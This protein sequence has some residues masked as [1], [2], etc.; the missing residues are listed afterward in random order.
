MESRRNEKNGEKTSSPKFYFLNLPEARFF[1]ALCSI[2]V[3]E[4]SDPLNEPGALTVGAINYIDST[5]FNFPSE[6]QAYFREAIDTINKHSQSQFSKEFSDLS[7][8]DKNIVLRGLYLDPKTRELSFDLRSLAL[9][10]FYSDYHDP[11]YEGMSGWEF[12]Q[13]GGKRISDIK[14]DWSFLKVWKEWNSEKSAKS[15]DS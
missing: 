14:K 4:G 6:V 10:S 11:W 5:L 8:P 12:V 9:E 3:P 7:D 15:G 1:E 13:F 2:I